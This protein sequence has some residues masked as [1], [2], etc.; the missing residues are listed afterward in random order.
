MSAAQLSNYLGALASQQFSNLAVTGPNLG[1]TGSA[2][3]MKIGN[4]YL[5]QQG[6]IQ[7][8]GSTT[9]PLPLPISQTGLT[10]NWCFLFYI[11]GA[12]PGAANNLNYLYMQ[13]CTI[14]PSGVATPGAFN[15]LVN[16]QTHPANITFSFTGTNGTSTSPGF[17]NIVTAVSGGTSYLDY[18]IIGLPSALF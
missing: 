17:F 12:Q 5:F 18:F 16:Q 11:V 9:I 6:Q 15:S 4:L 3:F 7:T 10:Q 8:G 14:T 1:A 13:N 2:G